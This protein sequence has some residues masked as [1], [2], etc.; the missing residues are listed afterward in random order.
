[1]K[2]ASSYCSHSAMPERDLA[3]GEV[4][5]GSESKLMTVGSFSFHHQVAQGLVVFL[6]QFSYP[7]SA[8]TQLK[9][10]KKSHT[11]FS[12]VPVLMTLNDSERL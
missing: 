6:Y 10:I 1:L 11:G 3:I 4:S 12:L 7:R 5:A 9:T 2:V 8:G